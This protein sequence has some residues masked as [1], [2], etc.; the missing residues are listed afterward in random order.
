MAAPQGRRRVEAFLAAVGGEPIEAKAA[1]QAIVK[2][3]ATALLQELRAAGAWGV[4]NDDRFCALLLSNEHAAFDSINGATLR[5][6]KTTLLG[7]DHAAQRERFTPSKDCLENLFLAEG[8]WHWLS[9]RPS[10]ELRAWCCS[11]GRM[12][13]A[14]AAAI[15]DVAAL[16]DYLTTVAF[17]WGALPD[18]L[19]PA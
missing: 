8:L 7:G 18:A 9:Q 3:S 1:L 11:V 15:D 19:A 17:P 13:A 6:V 14:R 4:C 12:S 10:E 5:R 2:L 16:A